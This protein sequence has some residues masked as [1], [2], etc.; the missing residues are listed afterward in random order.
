MEELWAWAHER[1]LVSSSVEKR[2]RTAPQPA[3][4]PAP[5]V[6]QPQSLPQPEP[7]VPR[8]AVAAEAAAQG[9]AEQALSGD[10]RGGE[11]ES[12][13]K[14]SSQDASDSGGAS[15]SSATVPA[16]ATCA[17]HSLA[18]GD[19]AAWP[20][21]AGA[22]H[23]VDVDTLGTQGCIVGVRR[24]CR[25]GVRTQILRSWRGLPPAASLSRSPANDLPPCRPHSSVPAACCNRASAM[26]GARRRRR[27]RD[28]AAA[29]GTARRPAPQSVATDGPGAG[30]VHAALCHCGGGGRQ[31]RGLGLEGVG[32]G[33]CRASEGVVRT[34]PGGRSVGS[35]QGCV[36]YRQVWGRLRCCR[37][38][39]KQSRVSPLP[40]MQSCSQSKWCNP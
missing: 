37:S 8:P 16:A 31:R 25:D 14:G 7:Q 24:A 6:L 12:G 9:G 28:V 22:A 1:G 36:G 3:S 29:A 2:G 17:N 27:D 10:T 35:G 21:V 26:H 18:W 20:M 39:P 34:K 19:L 40:L 5:A 13:G 23:S 38:A 11:A 4:S 33:R 32:A 15:T 30:A